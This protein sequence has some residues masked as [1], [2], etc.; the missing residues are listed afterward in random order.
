MGKQDNGDS[1]VS[2][3]EIYR[4]QYA[5]FS[6]MNDLLYKLPIAFST[7][8]GGLWFFAADMMT[9]NQFVAS[10][11]FLFTAICCTAFYL[12]MK[13]FGIAFNAYIDNLNL[14]DGKY[15][16]SIRKAGRAST[17]AV[18]R[19]LLLCAIVLSVLGFVYVSVCDPLGE[20]ISR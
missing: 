9:K 17:I 20:A 18:I 8:V 4:Q 16:V 13:R 2:V 6:R 12:V 14:L 5:H 3:D 1:R 10:T 19:G 11:V 15:Q 7:I